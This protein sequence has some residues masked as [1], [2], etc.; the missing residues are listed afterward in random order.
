MAGEET[1]RNKYSWIQ[2]S[3]SLLPF[4]P[5]KSSHPSRPRSVVVL[6]TSRVYFDNR[7]SPP[8]QELPISPG[9][10][11]INYLLIDLYCSD[12]LNRF[13]SDSPSCISLSLLR[14]D[15][16]IRCTQHNTPSL[17]L[18]KRKP[19]NGTECSRILRFCI[20]ISGCLLPRN[21]IPFSTFHSHV[22][23]ARMWIVDWL[24]RDWW[25]LSIKF[26]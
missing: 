10:V 3:V 7:P 22:G 20:S 11:S 23:M 1:L 17:P 15:L 8:D 26:K 19:M 24:F 12:K 6:I 16:V 25:S 5:I 18:E 21:P 4:P 9:R 14:R 2:Y 13:N